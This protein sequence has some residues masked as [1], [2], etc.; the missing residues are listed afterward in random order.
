VQRCLAL[1]TRAAAEPDFLPPMPLHGGDRERALKH[2]M[3]PL[4]PPQ[5][6]SGSA[7]AAAAAADTDTAAPAEQQTNLVATLGALREL[8]HMYAPLEVLGHAGLAKTLGKL[9]AHQ[10]RVRVG[11]HSLMGGGSSGAAWV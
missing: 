8:S 10:V 1:L 7:A 9:K 5:Q 6:R 3:Q 2:P 4:P 11:A